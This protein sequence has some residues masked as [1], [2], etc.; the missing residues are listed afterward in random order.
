MMAVVP[1]RSA[2][3]KAEGFAIYTGQGILSKT[4]FR[5]SSIGNLVF[6]HIE[7]LL[8]CFGKLLGPTH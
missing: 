3:L 2:Q 8:R 1:T 4:L 7:R 6:T 5:I